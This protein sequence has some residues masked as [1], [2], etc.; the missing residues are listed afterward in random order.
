MA[1]WP[2]RLGPPSLPEQSQ[3]YLVNSELAPLIKAGK[4][5]GV[6]M[7]LAPLAAAGANTG[8]DDVVMAVQQ[9]TAEKITVEL[10][11]AGQAL[12][13]LPLQAE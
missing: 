12:P 8:G 11:A 2:S 5:P 1:S 13:G 7:V 4:N 3:G 10:D 6:K 9:N